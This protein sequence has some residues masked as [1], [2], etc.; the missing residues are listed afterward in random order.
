[1]DAVKACSEWQQTAAERLEA[2]RWD[3]TES[4]TD[5]LVD[6]L[7]SLRVLTADLPAL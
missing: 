5:L 1:L 4:D 2:A 6:K 7:S 3:D